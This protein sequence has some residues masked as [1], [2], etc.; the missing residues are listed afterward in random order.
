[1]THNGNAAAA[2]DKLR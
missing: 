2:T 1:M